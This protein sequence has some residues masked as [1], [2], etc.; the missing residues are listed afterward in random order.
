MEQLAGENQDDYIQ[1]L[2][3][4]VDSL[5][6]RLRRAESERDA[7]RGERDDAQRDFDDKRVRLEW[8]TSQLTELAIQ[9]ASP[10]APTRKSEMARL[11][12]GLLEEQDWRHGAWRR[13][14]RSGS[15]RVPPRQA[16][17]G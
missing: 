3:G 17:D 15:A 12:S 5:D 10:S 13:L 1:R 14:P 6:S 9:I 16:Q 2:V 7:A 8:L 11:L 4:E